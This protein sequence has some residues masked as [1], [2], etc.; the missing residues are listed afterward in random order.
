MFWNVDD[1][2]WVSCIIATHFLNAKIFFSLSIHPKLEY[3]SI[4]YSGVTLPHV[5][6]LDNL[7]SRIENMCGFVFSSLTNRHNTSIMGFTCCLLHGEGW[8]NL[9]TFF[10]STFW[11]TTAWLSNRLHAFDP[12]SHLCLQNRT[13]QSLGCS[14]R[15]AVNLIPAKLLLQG[16]SV[17]WRTVLKDIQRAIMR[18]IAW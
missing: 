5:H 12:A 10:V 8:S 2:V 14:C 3:G 13:F 9:Q 11:T 18:C 1:N 15:T 4:L 16:D 6:Y 17:R 7:Q